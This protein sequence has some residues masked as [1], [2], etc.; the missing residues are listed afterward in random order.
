MYGKE[1]RYFFVMWIVMFAMPIP[2]HFYTLSRWFPGAEVPRRVD[3]STCSE[4]LLGVVL[5]YFGLRLLHLAIYDAALEAATEDA[6]ILLLHLLL[7]NLVENPP[8]PLCPAGSQEPRYLV[9]ST[10]PPAR[11]LFWGSS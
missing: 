4:S 9:E 7:A 10:Y 3:L 1:P 2:M 8:A 6:E 5:M 11:S